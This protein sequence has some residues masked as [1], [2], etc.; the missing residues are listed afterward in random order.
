VIEG[1][2]AEKEVKEKLKNSENTG[3][4]GGIGCYHLL[5]AFVKT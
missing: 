2:Q 4:T 5:T 3:M 1:K